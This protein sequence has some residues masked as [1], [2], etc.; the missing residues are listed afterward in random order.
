M[1]LQPERDLRV[2]HIPGD[3]CL[4]N[5][6]V[7]NLELPGLTLSH[8]GIGPQ[9]RDLTLRSTEGN[10]RRLR[11]HCIQHDLFDAAILKGWRALS[12]DIGGIVDTLTGGCRVA[13]IDRSRAHTLLVE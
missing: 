11:Q 4:Q 7:F 6:P 2:S 9:G 8:M 10:E 13:L 1:E 12:E 5:A 3:V